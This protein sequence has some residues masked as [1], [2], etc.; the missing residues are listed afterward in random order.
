MSFNP[1]KSE[2]NFASQRE[3]CGNATLCEHLLACAANASI[4]STEQFKLMTR[5]RLQPGR[6]LGDVAMWILLPIAFIASMSALG[7]VPLMAPVKS[8]HDRTPYGF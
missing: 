5:P 4:K 8:D 6:Q 1:R 7:L 2:R 3:W